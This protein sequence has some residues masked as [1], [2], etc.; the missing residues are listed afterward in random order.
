MLNYPQFILVTCKGLVELGYS[1]WGNFDDKY[2]FR[3]KQRAPSR[4]S[5]IGWA[6]PRMTSYSSR[7]LEDDDN[8]EWRQQPQNKPKVPDKF[9]FRSVSLVY[10]TAEVDE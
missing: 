5:L 3:A 6:V 9:I 10:F 7:V 4:Q 2:N 8:C 1:S